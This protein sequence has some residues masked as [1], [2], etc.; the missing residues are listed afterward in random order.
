MNEKYKYEKIR[1]RI[2]YKAVYCRRLHILVYEHEKQTRGYTK[3]I[4]F[5]FNQKLL[6]KQETQNRC[7]RKEKSA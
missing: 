6:E 3:A 1:N 4:N 7:N 2:E 5:S